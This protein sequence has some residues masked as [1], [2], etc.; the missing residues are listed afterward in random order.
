MQSPY[1]CFHGPMSSYCM[2]RPLRNVVEVELPSTCILSSLYGVL[3]ISASFLPYVRNSG[4]A[5]SQP[6]CAAPSRSSDRTGGAGAIAHTRLRRS[7]AT[8]S[9]KAATPVAYMIVSLT[10]TQHTV[11]TCP[12]IMFKGSS[13]L[14]RLFTTHC[15]RPYLPPRSPDNDQPCLQTK[16][17]SFPLSMM[18]QGHRVPD[19]SA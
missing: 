10:F 15:R 2:C 1:I 19:L 9:T 7:T 16:P 18:I 5:L 12:K 11:L 8:P 6:L 3:P 14:V 4:Q 17:W 13:F